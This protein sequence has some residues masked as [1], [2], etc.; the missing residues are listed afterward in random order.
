M[1][2]MGGTS[3]EE[4][5]G[6]PCSDGIRDGN[7]T[8]TDCGGPD[9]YACYPKS[10]CQADRDCRAGTCDAGYCRDLSC[11]DGVK[12]GIEAEV[13]CGGE[14]TAC[15]PRL[16]DCP[17]ASSAGL[18]PL[19]CGGQRGGRAQAT[20]DTLLFSL[21]QANPVPDGEG[22]GRCDLA[23]WTLGAGSEVL[24]GGAEPRGLSADGQTFLAQGVVPALLSPGV[25]LGLPL[26]SAAAMSPDGLMVLGSIAGTPLPQVARWNAVTGVVEAIALG[27]L[28][29]NAVG[30]EAMA[31]SSD[32]SVIA[33]VTVDSQA[34]PLDVF[35]WT[36]A[37]G[38]V[39][40]AEAFHFGN[41]I[42]RSGLSLSDD[43]SVL[44]G[45]MDFDPSSMVEYAVA[46]R[47]TEATGTLPIYGT[48][49]EPTQLGLIHGLS[50]DGRLV[51]GTSFD[52]G[53]FLWY[54][55]SDVRRLEQVLQAAGVSLDGWILEGTMALSGD[56]RVVVG[57]GYCGD[58]PALYRAVIAE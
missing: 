12:N 15:P 29:A 7:E 38:L 44:V 40:I 56:G 47:W 27:P 25:A 41:D 1:G 22:P 9:C 21:C 45:T 26:L 35:R 4:P 39:T 37:G 10:S 3:F 58:L 53:P 51:L 49:P 33:G 43:G 52:L 46:F 14:C 2:G 28:P 17:C 18:A 11:Y 20:S 6:D 5:P 48:A 42:R 24:I 23:R 36:E 16:S 32:G 30:A 13:D 55:V 34:R 50:G 31:M 57:H 19:A 54:E 8:D